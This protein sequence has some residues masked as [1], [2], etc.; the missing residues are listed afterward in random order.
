MAGDARSFMLAAGIGLVGF[1]WYQRYKQLDGGNGDPTGPIPTFDD[2]TGVLTWGDP[3]VNGVGVRLSGQPANVTIDIQG[4][5]PGDPYTIQNRRLSDGVAVSQSEGIV[6]SS[7]RVLHEDLQTIIPV[8]DPGAYE[9]VLIYHNIVK[10]L[11]PGF[12]IQPPLSNTSLAVNLDEPVFT[13]PD[14]YEDWL[15]QNG[16]KF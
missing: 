12:I 7:G 3:Q 11:Q 15:I 14:L 2:I 13:N 6:P 5:R 4:M 10:N 9:V 8:W 16:W 1:A